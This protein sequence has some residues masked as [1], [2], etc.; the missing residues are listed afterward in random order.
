MGLTVHYKLAHSGPLTPD[1]TEALVRTAQRRAAALV[2]RR[3]LAEIGPVIDAHCVDL[4]ANET[5]FEK[6][7]RDTLC[8]DVPVEQ[9]WLFQVWPG[10]D[11]ETALFGLCRYPARIR[12]GRRWRPTGCAGWRW[13]SFCKTQYAHLHGPEH[14]LRC[15]RAVIDLAHIWQRLGCS[16]RIVDEGGYWP[17]RDEARVLREVGFLECAIAGLAGAAKDAT[18]GRGGEIRSPIFAHPHF[19]R[20]EAEGAARLGERLQ[21]AGTLIQHLGGAF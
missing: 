10:E 8:H 2:R 18:D 1:G 20:I 3:E 11:C 7:G 19:E 9:G 16:I 6:S 15:H 13:S 21:Q 17:E 5:V 4:L 12:V 14:F